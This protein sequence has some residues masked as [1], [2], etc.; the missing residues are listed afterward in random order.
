MKQI[1]DTV[2]SFCVPYLAKFASHEFFGV[3]N[4][5]KC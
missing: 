2:I 1:Q 3:D 4:S 5:F